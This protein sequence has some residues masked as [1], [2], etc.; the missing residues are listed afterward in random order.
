MR[1]EWGI[2][3]QQGSRR[4]LARRFSK[5]KILIRESFCAGDQG[6][7]PQFPRPERGVLPLHQ[8]P[9]RPLFYHRFLSPCVRFRLGVSRFQNITFRCEPRAL[10]GEWAKQSPHQ[11]EVASWGYPRPCTPAWFV[12]KGQTTGGAR[13]DIYPGLCLGSTVHRLYPKFR[14]E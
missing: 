6:F 14:E 5:K 1:I 9:K 13:D 10:N 11:F 7:E 8:S 4:Q 3:Y 12:P 2:V